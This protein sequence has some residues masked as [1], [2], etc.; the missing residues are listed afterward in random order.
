M[1]RNY[2]TLDDLPRSLREE[3]PELAQ[4]TYLYAYRRTWNGARMSGVEDE[5]ELAR[6]AHDAAML[7]VRGQFEKNERGRWVHAPVGD[8]IDRDKLEGGAPDER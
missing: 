5:E 2:E 3:L 4:Q 7:A 1:N 8:A 6:T